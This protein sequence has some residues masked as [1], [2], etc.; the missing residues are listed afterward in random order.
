MAIFGS[1]ARFFQTRIGFVIIFQKTNTVR[2][3]LSI[4]GFGASF[5]AIRVGFSAYY[6][7]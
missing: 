5:F 3:Y 6:C 2:N 1:G 7:P 4:V